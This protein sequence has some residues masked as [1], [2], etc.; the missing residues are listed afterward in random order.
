[1]PRTENGARNDRK[2]GFPLPDQV[3]DRFR[4]NDKREAPLAMTEKMD[5][6]FR[7]NDKKKEVFFR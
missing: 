7:G 4:G 2:D 3:E 6:R 5:S 1:L